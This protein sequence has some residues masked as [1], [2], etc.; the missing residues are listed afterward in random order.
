MQK[1]RENSGERYK[2]VIR[3][4]RIFVLSVFVIVVMLC[5]CLFT[6]VFGI[7][8]IMVSGNS[9]VSSEDVIAASGIE[10]G[11][12]VFRVNISKAEKK[13]FAVP[14]VEGVQIKRK[15]PARIEIVIDEAKPD[16]IM[17]TP[18]Q[19][20]VTT[21]NGR[22]LE[23]TEDVT[24]LTSPLVYG[25]KV[26]G[27]EP[28]KQLQTE[29]GETFATNIAYIKCFYDTE[30]W[31]N[32]DEFHVSDITNFVIIMKSG[33]KVT[34]G[35]IEST[36]ALRRKIM[37]MTKI[38]EQVKQSERSYLDLTTYKGYYGEYTYA[39][40]EEMKKEAEG[41]ID[42]EDEDSKQNE[43]K[44]KENNS[45]KSEKKEQTEKAEKSA[46]PK[47]SA[48]PSDVAEPR[49]KASADTDRED[50]TEGEADSTP[51]DSKS[52]TQKKNNDNGE[53]TD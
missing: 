23:I 10:K 46:T 44:D 53:E 50:K 26:T 8:N 18:T 39:E 29:D 28:A 15:F 27:A 9:V 32:I 51:S 41:I 21:V 25:V 2:R 22:V 37:M 20:V 6:P 52:G 31:Q 12:N 40:M 19:F 42:D 34:F 5:I 11:E 14:Y 4:R 17:D 7:S 49:K 38:L 33:M 45:K 24:H 47:A 3:Q 1:R 16:I 30:H 36:E 48:K 43:E 35:S 13:L